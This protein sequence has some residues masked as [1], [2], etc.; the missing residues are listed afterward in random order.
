MQDKYINY[1]IKAV[2]NVFSTMISLNPVPGKPIPRNNGNGIPGQKDITGIMGICGTIT[3]SIIIHFEKSIALKATS[4]MLGIEY[5][6]IDSDVKDAV[7]E[8]TNMVS[9]A[10]KA[11]FS[12]SGIDLTLSLPIVICGKDFETNSLNGDSAILIPFEIDDKKFYVE[13]SFK[14]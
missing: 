1:I 6:E 3:A 14:E 11:E 9:G 7:G 10:T 4:N 8:I 12:N 13:F 5:T 2:D